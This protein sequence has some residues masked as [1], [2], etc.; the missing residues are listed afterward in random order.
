MHIQCR[1]Q[2]NIQS[3]IKSKAAVLFHSPRF[4]FST[5]TMSLSTTLL[6][7]DCLQLLTART[8]HPC[9]SF[10]TIEQRPSKEAYACVRAQ[11]PCQAYWQ[12]Q[13]RFEP[14]FLV[15]YPAITYIK[16]F[17]FSIKKTCIDPYPFSMPQQLQATQSIDCDPSR[18]KVN[19]SG[20]S[21]KGRWKNNMDDL[22]R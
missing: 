13:C 21:R 11:V 3:V 17:Y 10:A 19:E 7:L 4:L 15:L 12:Q 18:Y 14:W 20:L 9:N 1:D 5:L 6:K 2:C 8:W 16:W 22:V